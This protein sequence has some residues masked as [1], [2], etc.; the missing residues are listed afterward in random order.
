L[1][2]LDA[3]LL[4]WLPACIDFI[5]TCL[6]QPEEAKKKEA[7]DKGEAEGNPVARNILLVHW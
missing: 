1:D 7:K 4:S 5:A 6:E 3:D 2:T